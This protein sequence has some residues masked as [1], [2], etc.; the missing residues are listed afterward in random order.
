MQPPPCCE[1][2]LN[3]GPLLAEK[4]FSAIFRDFPRFSAVC[5][6]FKGVS[7]FLYRFSYKTA[8][9]A[10]RGRCGRSPLHA[11]LL[12]QLGPAVTPPTSPAHY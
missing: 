6:G 7:K 4:R 12:A 3:A 9:W 8:G 5:C 11:R 1:E 10:G 2:N